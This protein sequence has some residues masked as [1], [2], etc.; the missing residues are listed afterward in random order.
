M[1]SECRSRHRGPPLQ[2]HP[3]RPLGLMQQ[4][5]QNQESQS[6]LEPLSELQYAELPHAGRTLIR[7]SKPST[8]VFKSLPESNTLFS[9]DLTPG[10][11]NKKRISSPFTP[12]FCWLAM[13]G[14]YGDIVAERK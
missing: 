10:R 3:R 13:A 8:S 9:F 6:A 5:L 4:R 7:Q 2:K 12:D 14:K 1:K 11:S